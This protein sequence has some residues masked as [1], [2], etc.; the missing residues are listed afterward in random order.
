M[1]NW[2]ATIEEHKLQS[3]IGARASA[4][5]KE[6]GIEYKQITAVMDIGACH[7]NGNPL[8]LADLLEADEVNFAHDVFGIKA[9]I[10]RATGKLMN[11]FVPRYSD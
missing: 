7:G 3:K 4:L 5:A 2:E 1:I 11:C 9:N 6:V 8:R 10:D